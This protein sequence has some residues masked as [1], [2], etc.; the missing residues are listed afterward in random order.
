MNNKMLPVVVVSML[1]AA[2]AFTAAASGIAL[3]NEDQF[4]ADWPFTKSEMHLSCLPGNAVVVMDVDT[5]AMYPVN[6]PANQQA[7][8]RGMEP[9]NNV[10][11]DNPEIAGTK[12]S[13]SPVLERGLRLC[14]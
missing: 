10:W 4:G 5:A 14:K 6:G 1:M 3:I 9:L 7:K 11:R 2:T 13:I 8:R 12:V